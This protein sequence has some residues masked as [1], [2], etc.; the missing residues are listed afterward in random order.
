MDKGRGIPR[1][2][3][4]FALVLLLAACA[5]FAPRYDATLDL[6]TTGAYELVAGFAASAEL[7]SYTEKDS[8]EAIA[9]QYAN[10]QAQLAVA[11]L[12]AATLPT[13]GKAA[14]KARDLLVALIQGCSDRVGSFARQH[15]AFGIQPASGATEPMMISC[16]QAAKAAQ[17]M[18]T[19]N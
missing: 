12:R 10:A 16:D 9:P 11:K 8:F 17:A 19:G 3:I 5:M 18:K 15:A 6:K 13:Q 4:A 1:I 2:G 7:G 14:E